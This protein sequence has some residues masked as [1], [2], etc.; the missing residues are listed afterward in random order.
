MTR[1]STHPQPKQASISKV[2]AVAQPAPM[3]SIDDVKAVVKELI[4][5]N[6]SSIMI[7]AR[8]QAA[9]TARRTTAAELIRQQSAAMNVAS[10]STPSVITSSSSSSSRLS[11]EERRAKRREA[12]A[13]D[14]AARKAQRQK[15]G[16]LRY[17][18]KRYQFEK[19]KRHEEMEMEE[20]KKQ[21]D[22]DRWKQ[23]AAI[24]CDEVARAN[25]IKNGE[26]QMREDMELERKKDEA[27]L[28]Y[29]KIKEIRAQQE[30]ARML[31]KLE[32]KNLVPKLEGLEQWAKNH[33]LLQHWSNRDGN[34][35]TIPEAYLKKEQLPS[36]SSSRSFKTTEQSKVINVVDDDI[37]FSSWQRA[38]FQPPPVR[39][40]QQQ[41]YLHRASSSSP[42]VSPPRNGGGIKRERDGGHDNGTC[43]SSSSSKR[44][45]RSPAPICGRTS[46]IITNN[47]DDDNRDTSHQRSRHRSVSPSP[48]TSQF[49]NT[50][51]YDEYQSDHECPQ[52][53][54]TRHENPTTSRSNN[55]INTAPSSSSS[56]P[57]S[58]PSSSTTTLHIIDEVVAQMARENSRTPSPSPSPLPFS[59]LPSLS[60]SSSVISGDIQ[61]TSLVTINDP[62]I[63]K[64]MEETNGTVMTAPNTS[65]HEIPPHIYISQLPTIVVKLEPNTHHDDD[66]SDHIHS[67]TNRD[68]DGTHMETPSLATSLVPSQILVAEQH[69]AEVLKLI[70]FNSPVVDSTLPCA[71]EESKVTSVVAGQLVAASDDDSKRTYACT[72]CTFV[73]R[74][75]R[76]RCEICGQYR[77]PINPLQLS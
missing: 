26:R 11:R 69:V 73:N 72:V 59:S 42:S 66:Y 46:A 19:Q 38:T 12:K 67:I 68:M 77:H 30:E 27:A 44:R 48:T 34:Q 2:A 13:K 55:R 15:D 43:Q 41:Q 28:N 25:A 18:Q 64:S 37:S 10:S 51:H 61:Q 60:S 58:L 75:H 9:I 20:K 52:H 45:S 14:R 4:D 1:V 8:E 62:N 16:D 70:D 5:N 40:Q 29:N 47:H 32:A 22:H 54:R 36:P 35:L 71:I 7:H 76:V 31:A 49:R 6:E 53:D 3:I 74:E 17:E 63:M 65:C 24:N 39:S 21:A 56:S 23:Q 50:H 57:S 33:P